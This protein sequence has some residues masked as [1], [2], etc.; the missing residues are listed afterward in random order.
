MNVCRILAAFL[1]AAGCTCARADAQGPPG[2]RILVL[3]FENSQ[4]EPRFGWLGE[5]SGIATSSSEASE[6]SFAAG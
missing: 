2:T 5:A 3:P 6:T 4:R 1:L